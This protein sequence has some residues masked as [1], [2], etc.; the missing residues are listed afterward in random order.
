M[1]IH[2]SREN[3]DLQKCLGVRYATVNKMLLASLP[4]HFVKGIEAYFF[5]KEEVTKYLLEQ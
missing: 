4:V 1:I 5:N 2:G 3:E